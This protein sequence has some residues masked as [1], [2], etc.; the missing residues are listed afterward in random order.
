MG[1]LRW[2]TAGESHGPQLT[3]ILEGCPAGLELSRAEI[4]LQ[5]ARRQRGY[6]RG[7][8]QLI[9][10]DRVRILGGV[11]HGRTTGAPIALAIANRDAENWAD[12]MAVDGPGVEPQASETADPTRE[13]EGGSPEGPPGA[14]ARDEERSAMV[15]VPRPGHADLGGALLYDLDDIRD[16]IERSSAR[17]TAA[18][19][20]CG[21]VARALLESVGC[22]IGSH[23]VAIGGVEAEATLGLADLER[24]DADDVRCLDAAAADRMRAA[25]DAAAADGDTLGGVFEVCA[26]GYPF[27]VGSYVQGDLR[28]G[29]RLAGAVMSINAIKGVEIG[30]GFA[31][32]TR[33]GSEVQDPIVWD[34]ETGYGRGSN[35]AGGIDGGIS[36][37]ETIVVRAA[38]KPIATLRAPLPTVTLGSHVRVESRY[39][40]SDT[41]A[42]P[43]A[44]LVGEAM[45]A[46]T[47]ADG[48][49]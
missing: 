10:Q 8:R 40:R 15:D 18:R 39:E 22:R 28:L 1:R 26:F 19:V 2:L 42:V 41:C 45:V 32:A 31:A 11:R 3:A 38:M 30:M 29:A 5:L 47:L 14:R 6:G 7:P 20:A 35:H 4:D 13:A 17:E 23:V 37:G 44:A 46:L 25:I 43:A 12:V 27:G 48:L 36:T 34:E 49:L 33:R 16:V 9:E 24:V 21:A